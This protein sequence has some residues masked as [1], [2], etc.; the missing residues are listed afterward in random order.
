MVDCRSVCV[1][2]AVSSFKSSCPSGIRDK[3]PFFY[4][5][6]PLHIKNK[7]CPLLLTLLAEKLARH[8]KEGADQKR[9]GGYYRL[10]LQQKSVF[11]VFFLLMYD[12]KG[13]CPLLRMLALRARKGSARVEVL[14]RLAKIKGSEYYKR[15]SP[16]FILEQEILFSVKSGSKRLLPDALETA[17]TSRTAK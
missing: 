5:F 7:N 16:G 11:R 6:F 17:L 10:Q 9:R 13:R 2:C 15:Q 14:L 12:W 4:F 8:K 3:Q 1:E